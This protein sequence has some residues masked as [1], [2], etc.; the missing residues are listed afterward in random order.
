MS[1]IEQEQVLK[2]MSIIHDTR[3]QNTERARRRYAAF[4]CP[5]SA[6]VLDFGDYTYNARL[7]DGKPIFDETSKVFP[8]IS[9]ERKMSLDELAGC[10]T[11]D[12]KRFEAE[13]VRAQDHGSRVFLLCEN[14]TWENLLLGRYRSKF[15][16][17]SFLAS[18]TAWE[19]RYNLQ[20]IFCKEETSP[21]LIKEILYRDLKE[22]LTNGQFG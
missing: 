13:M 12:R 9:I 3:E 2:S 22:R 14:S 20:L 8:Y 15:R 21:R 16:P 6:C 17:Q 7:L 10:F 19:I 5:V 1:P 11:H 4:G 18:I